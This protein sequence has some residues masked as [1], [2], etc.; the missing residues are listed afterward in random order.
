MNIFI[1]GGA[2]Y[3]GS[4]TVLEALRRKHR[5]FVFDS[6]ERGYREAL[7]RVQVLANKQIIFFKGDLRKREEIA[8]ALKDT[9]PDIVIHFAAYK[10]VG[11]GEKE[12][13]KY[14]KNN[15]EATL[16]LLDEMIKNKINKLI[17][18]SSAATYGIVDHMP[19]TEQSPTNPIS[20]YGK[21]KLEMEKIIDSFTKTYGLE[22]VAFRYFNAVGA[23]ES[24]EIGEDPRH[25]TNLVPLV[26]QTLIGKR[27]KVFLFGD[28]FE[29]ADGTQERDY[30]HVSDLATAHLDAAEK[31]FNQGEMLILNLST[32]EK[33]SCLQVFRLAEE[34]SGRKLNYEVIDPRQGDPVILY[35][36]NSKA[37]F[38]LG[39]K[40]Q[41]DIKK[42]IQ[43]QWRWTSK[44]PDGYNY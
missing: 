6:L 42:S 30:I 43:D 14:Y 22:S 2:G 20:V 25:S 10:S 38:T 21:T 31:S 32:G 24:G 7:D 17:F 37:K 33:T 23:D 3:I 18:S 41:R 36:D 19:I 44:Y 27:E 1:T 26:M 12:P 35:A 5:V 34:I 16:I 11:E 4:H 15:V 29:T 28:K 13:D 9:K 39:W 8:D 40:P